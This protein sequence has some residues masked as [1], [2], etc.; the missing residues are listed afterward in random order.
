MWNFLITTSCFQATF[1]KAQT[2]LTN[3]GKCVSSGN[4]KDQRETPNLFSDEISIHLDSES[5]HTWSAHCEQRIVVGPGKGIPLPFHKKPER[6]G[7]DNALPC[8]CLS[9]HWKC[10][11]LLTPNEACMSF[12]AHSPWRLPGLPWQEV[13]TFSRNA[14][15]ALFYRRQCSYVKY[16]GSAG[17][18]LGPLSPLSKLLQRSVP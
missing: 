5:T 3:K 2:A 17:H 8:L 6:K 1:C 16:L 15:P 9:L 11:S 4:W 7:K 10:F 18:C 14:T 12:I 13:R